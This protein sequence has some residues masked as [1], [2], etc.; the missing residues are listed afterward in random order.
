MAIYTSSQKGST[1]LAIEQS[2]IY[3][4]LLSTYPHRLK[5]CLSA[6]DLIGLPNSELIYTIAAIENASGFCEENE[7]LQDGFTKFENLLKNCGK[8]LYVGFTH[9]GENRFGGGNSTNVG[10]KKDGKVLLDFL[11]GKK[12]ALDLSH[13]SDALA[14]EQLDYISKHNLKIPILA[15]HSNFRAVFNHPRNLSDELAKEIIR[16]KGVIGINLLRAFLND[17]DE[18]AVYD[19]LAYAAEIGAENA[20]CF[21]ADYFYTASHPDQTRDPFFYKGQ[22][23]SA[24]YPEIL[25][26]FKVMKPNQNLDLV[27][28]KNALAF[29]QRLWS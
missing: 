24:C 15:S 19:H 10:L 4:S 9:H 3:N 5:A 25:S 27:S 28:H 26:K 21:G 16:Q 12:I 8:I 23:S 20:I 11:S 29:I 1:H 13:T 17:R 6:K 22:D 7:P 14:N 18:N 2:K